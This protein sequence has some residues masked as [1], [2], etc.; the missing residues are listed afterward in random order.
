M[1]NLIFND[2]IVDVEFDFG[3]YL[4]SKEVRFY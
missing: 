1:N 3:I 4:E 2:E